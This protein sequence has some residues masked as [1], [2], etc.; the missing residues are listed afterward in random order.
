MVMNNR[1]T[2]K[3]IASIKK[4]KGKPFRLEEELFGVS[5]FSYSV[6]GKNL[7]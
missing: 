1:T 5:I 7:G 2:K 6:L 3:F 4:M